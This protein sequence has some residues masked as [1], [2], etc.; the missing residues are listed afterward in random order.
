MNIKEAIMKNAKAITKDDIERAMR[1]ARPASLTGLAKA[2]GYKGSIGGGL[3][4]TIRGLVP[5]IEEVLATNKAAK[6]IETS[7]KEGAA[8]AGSTRT[9]DT[10]PTTATA[11]PKRKANAAAK[12]VQKHAEKSALKADRKW[13]RD[14]RNVYREGSSYATAYDILAAHKSGMTRSKLVELL[15]AATGKDL[16]HS[17]WDAH[18]V[19]TAWGNEPGL[20]RNDG[21]RHRSARPGYW[22]KRE[23]GHVTLVVD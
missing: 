15:A 18:V 10:V 14:P 22:V 20:S 12:P 16:K 6:E 1:E 11:T 13:R 19:L 9:E 2:L 5:G 8:T 3:A 4:K 21:P 17:G 7:A 23:N